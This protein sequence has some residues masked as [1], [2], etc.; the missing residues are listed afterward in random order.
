M[1]LHFIA[2]KHRKLWLRKNKSQE[3]STSLSSFLSTWANNTEYLPLKQPVSLCFTKC[4]EARKTSVKIIL[5]AKLW[6]A[7]RGL[8]DCHHWPKSELSKTRKSKHVLDMDHHSFSNSSFFKIYCIYW[9]VLEDEVS[10]CHAPNKYSFSADFTP[11]LYYTI[12]NTKT[13]FGAYLLGKERTN[14]YT[15][16]LIFKMAWVWILALLPIDCLLRQVISFIW[17]LVPTSA[18][19]HN[20]R[21]SLPTPESCCED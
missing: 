4:L 13:S 21:W 19:R 14:M 16:W 18:N 8:G 6:K 17:T 2:L 11:S 3:K 5:V 1:F 10:N 12:V 7:P 20:K 9:I 15:I